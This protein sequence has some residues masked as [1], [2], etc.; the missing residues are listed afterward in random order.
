MVHEIKNKSDKKILKEMTDPHRHWLKI[1]FN[2]IFKASV[3]VCR[4]FDKL[5]LHWAPSS[6]ALNKK[7]GKSFVHKWKHFV[8]LVSTKGSKCHHDD[9]KVF[10]S[11]TD[12][13]NTAM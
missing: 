12:G 2:W 1:Y 3:H 9:F 13:K 11:S 5:F 4:L 10:M 6:S 7:K 8:K